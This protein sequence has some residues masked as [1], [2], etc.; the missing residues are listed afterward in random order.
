M[1]NDPV[2]DPIKIDPEIRP[3][4]GED[5]Y[6]VRLELGASSRDMQWLLAMVPTKW[7]KSL[8]DSGP[9]SNLTTALIVRWMQQNQH[10]VPIHDIISPVEFFEVSEI[11]LSVGDFALSEEQFCFALGRSASALSRW[12]V[13]GDEP[14]AEASNLIYYLIKEI[15]S[16]SGFNWARLSDVAYMVRAELNRSNETLDDSNNGGYKVDQAVS[17]ILSEGGRHSLVAVFVNFWRNWLKVVEREQALR[18]KYRASE[19]PISL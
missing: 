13:T 2:E 14:T 7:A 17:T 18:K 5:L 1:G 19:A 16:L 12:R 4:V 3:V 6:Q 9:V 15:E 10:L 8:R 11:L